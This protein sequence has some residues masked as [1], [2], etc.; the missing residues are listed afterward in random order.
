MTDIPDET[1]KSLRAFQSW[2]DYRCL[3]G[4]DEAREA[5]LAGWSASHAAAPPQPQPELPPVERLRP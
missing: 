1:L 4:M 3:V 2:W 5:F